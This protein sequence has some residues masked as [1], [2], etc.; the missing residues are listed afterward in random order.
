MKL[1]GLFG[2]IDQGTTSTRFSLFARD[3]AV[4]ASHQVPIPQYYRGPGEHTQDPKSYLTATLDC[5]AETVKKADVTKA[6]VA[7]IGITNQ[8]E[9]IIAWDIRTKEPLAEAIVWD[10]VRTAKDCEAVATNLGGPNALREVTGLPINTYFSASKI[11]W[12]IRNNPAVKSALNQ[13]NCCFSTVDSWL[14]S[15]LTDTPTPVTDISNAS[16][17]LLM[18]LQ[19]KWEDQ[20]CAL[21][22]LTPRALPVIKSSAEVY[23]KMTVGAL[24]GV[25]ICGALGDQQAALLGHGCTEVGQ[26]KNTY[27]TGS[28]L[29]VNTGNT[30]KLS[31]CG[32]ITSVYGQFG[33]SMPINYVL[34]GA[35]E[36]AGSC[37]NWAISNLNLAKDISDFTATAQS[38]PDNGG[39]YFVPALGGLYTPYWR[40]DARGLFIG[41][42]QHTVRGHLLRAILEGIAFRT[43]EAIAAVEKDLGNPVEAVSVDGGMTANPFFLQLQADIC[44]KSLYV[45]PSRELTSVGAVLAARVGCGDLQDWKETKNTAQ[46][47]RHFQPK[48]ANT[49]LWWAN[50]TAAI[51]RSLNWVK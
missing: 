1:R 51:Q 23:G 31:N 27:G 45:P 50:W 10:D 15:Q 32:L 47:L 48:A 14:L 25:P 40:N 36:A 21:F 37:I 35:V 24:Q 2:A 7:G 16:R 9:T 30:S 46:T 43:G 6:D 44:G 8:R 28:F 12:L 4:V 41:M 11:S 20:I 49:E 18:N 13:G 22:G 5:I 33:P 3:G 39:V 42:T 26:M 34:E 29:L 38:V 19:G 17:T